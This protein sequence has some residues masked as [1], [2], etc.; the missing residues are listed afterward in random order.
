MDD[1]SFELKSG[2]CLGLLGRNGAKKTTLLKSLSG[3][4][5]PNKGTITLKPR[6]AT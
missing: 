6:L 2:E 4:I 1:V 5:K 3:F